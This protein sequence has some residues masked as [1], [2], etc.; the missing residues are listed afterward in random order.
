MKR[1][2][3]FLMALAMLTAL[4]PAALA[5]GTLPFAD[6]QP[7][8]WAYDDIVWAYEEGY[9]NGKS[10]AAF[11]PG[12]S[13]T[14]QQVCMV[15][16]RLAGEKPANMGEAL[17][18]AL[19]N[20]VT[21]GVKPGGAITRQ[22][23]VT[24]LW[25]CMG[26]PEWDC[27]NVYDNYTYSN[28]ARYAMKSFA[29]AID[30]G[31]IEGVGGKDLAP[32]GL[33]SRAQ[34][35]AILHRFSNACGGEVDVLE[36]DDGLTGYVNVPRET[37]L[38]SVR[39]RYGIANK[40]NAANMTATAVFHDGLDEYAACIPYGNVSVSLAQ[41]F[42][43]AAGQYKKVFVTFKAA[44]GAGDTA[45][46]NDLSL[47]KLQVSADGKT[48]TDSGT[49]FTVESTGGIVKG[50]KTEMGECAVYEFTSGNIAP[51]SGTLKNIRLQ[52]QGSE[53]TFRLLSVYVWAETGENIRVP[54]LGG[55]TNKTTVGGTVEG[56]FLFDVGG[57]ISVGSGTSYT[58]YET[59]FD[60][61]NS[62]T[63]NS[64]LREQ[65]VVSYKGEEHGAAAFLLSR[66]AVMDGSFVRI[67]SPDMTLDTG[68]YDSIPVEFTY[69]S[70]PDDPAV[71][72]YVGYS[73]DNGTTWDYLDT[74]VSITRV[75]DGVE[76]ISDAQQE[77][78]ELPDGFGPT[79]VGG[80][81]GGEAAETW[82]ASFDIKKALPDTVVTNVVII[83]F[84]E[85]AMYTGSKVY[86]E[87][88]NSGAF[89]M[90]DFSLQATTSGE[91]PGDVVPVYA[92][93]YDS[94][95][96]QMMINEARFSGKNEVVI[97]SVNPRDGSDTWVI[98]KTIKLPSNMTLYINDCTLWA[99]ESLVGHIITNETSWS[100]DVTAADEQKNIHIIGLG[101]ATLHGG[102][103]NGLT[104]SNISMTGHS[105][106]QVVGLMLRNVNGFSIQNVREVETR[107]W[108][109]AMMWCRNGEIRGIDVQD[110]RLVP[111]QDGI[112]LRCG[113]NNVIYDDITGIS[114]DDSVALN[115]Y[116][117][118]SLE[119][120]GKDNDIY[121]VKISNVNTR[122]V[123]LR[124][125]VRLG[126]AEGCKIYNVDIDG[127]RDAH[128]DFGG[129]WATASVRVGDDKYWKTVAPVAGDITDI[130]VKNVTADSGAAIEICDL[131]VEFGR[132]V[133]YD[134]A[135]VKN[136][137]A[138]MMINSA[139]AAVTNRLSNR[140]RQ[141]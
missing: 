32:T 91:A 109:M 36:V 56:D 137:A 87:P 97:P 49:S 26:E 105:M 30:M 99:D 140:E 110:S 124:M 25:R 59:E 64:L 60:N 75:Y 113:C 58:L 121:N 95:V 11:E 62:W 81:S 98:T 46:Q 106:Q 131:S 107:F 115:A 63:S 82:R 8:H 84:G 80:G 70:E 73:T 118:Y 3:S 42:S 2:V 41:P 31:I 90:V 127:V 102:N 100:V 23:M 74:N 141:S 66:Q 83:P 22:E 104:S 89:R 125:Q 72:L 24:Y 40:L 9:M 21:D 14:R 52:P 117:T 50:A 38:A 134:A 101:D 79:P 112:D 54:V 122:L 132:D 34:F 103:G 96:I 55:N 130:T 68:L 139:Q 12:G 18:W 61:M 39:P 71:D 44:I 6:V 5:A 136:M 76:L 28:I 86:N 37:L 108:G 45:L 65:N 123:D 138:G 7:D 48:F 120:P 17:Q 29:W 20:G 126:V 1:I 35:A 111:E 128:L 119:V 93:H 33:L 27:W 116:Q 47:V 88:Y 15:L 69:Y 10:A 13:V 133:T 85:Q 4:V 135:T 53:G 129:L 19:S 78:V 92:D 67:F 94:R 57:G 77:I 114:G 16:A 51:A 43:A